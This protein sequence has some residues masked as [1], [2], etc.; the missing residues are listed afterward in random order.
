MGGLAEHYRRHREA[1]MLALELKCTP[2]EAQEE[3]RRR[4]ARERAR[5]AQ[6]RLAKKMAATPDD[7]AT[8]T[9]QP[10]WMRD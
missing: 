8:E 1:F 7:R 5:Q 4:E 3:L 10:W 2:K 9:P 6:H